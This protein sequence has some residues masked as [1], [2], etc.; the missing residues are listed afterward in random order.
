MPKKVT[1]WAAADGSHHPSRE[2][3]ENHD[4]IEDVTDVIAE[5]STDNGY[6]FQMTDVRSF[7]DLLIMTDLFA[8]LKS[9]LKDKL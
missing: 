2:D 4:L 7:A 6:S 3:A 5:I 1:V 9:V 8:K